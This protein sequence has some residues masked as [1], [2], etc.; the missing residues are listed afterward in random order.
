[1]YEKLHSDTQSPKKQRNMF[2]HFISFLNLNYKR[3]DSWI[4]IYTFLKYTV[5]KA[6][7]LFILTK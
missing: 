2:N 7:I 6:D 5:F 4:Y 3:P 1:M